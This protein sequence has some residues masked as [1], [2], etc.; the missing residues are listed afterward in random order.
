MLLSI[1]SASLLGNLSSGKWDFRVGDEIIKDSNETK[2]ETV[3]SFDKHRDQ[4]TLSI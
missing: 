2:K 3:S 4:Q 1:L